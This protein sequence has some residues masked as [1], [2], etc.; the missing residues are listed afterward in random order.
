FSCVHPL[1][2]LSVQKQPYR[3]EPYKTLCWGKAP[4]MGMW[5]VWCTA[6]LCFLGARHT[7]AKI[8]QTPSLVL[9][10]GQT[11]QL[12]C[13]QTDNHDYMYWYQQQQG[14]GLQLI[15][16][17]LGKDNQEDGDSDIKNDFTVSR[18]QIKVFDLNITSVKM[19][20]LAVYFCASSLDT[21]LQSHLLLL[22]KPPPCK[23]SSPPIST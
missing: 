20:H 3:A 17:S 10:K 14:K 11:A 12:T 1:W 9:K 13:K 8:T 22:Q 15:Y 7:D 18:P 6:A 2:C 21:A 4:E 23:R 5:L 16:Y 19:E